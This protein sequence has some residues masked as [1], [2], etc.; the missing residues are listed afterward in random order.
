MIISTGEE[1]KCAKRLAEVVL[2]GSGLEVERRP[3]TQEPSPRPYCRVVQGEARRS[4][5]VA[6][7]RRQQP[8]APL[9]L[10]PKS[11]PQPARLHPGHPAPRARARSAR[12]QRRA[13][14]IPRRTPARLHGHRNGFG[15][16][17]A[18]QGFGGL[19]HLPRPALRLR[20]CESLSAREGGMGRGGQCRALCPPAHPGT[21]LVREHWVG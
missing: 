15:R 14:L 11:R 21:A 6:G 2:L 10:A 1:S 9:S 12:S 3:G 13:P 17:P 16:Q 8:G 19:H 4:R 20:V 18:A 5:A 7:P